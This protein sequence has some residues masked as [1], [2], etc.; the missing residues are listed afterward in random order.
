MG[1]LPGSAREGRLSSAA[2]Q[3]HF[4]HPD[5]K[6]QHFK[7][8]RIYGGEK[9]IP[10]IALVWLFKK[11]SEVSRPPSSSLAP[12]LGIFLGSSDQLHHHR[13]REMNLKPLLMSVFVKQPLW[14]PGSLLIAKED[15]APSFPNPPAQE[16]SATICMFFILIMCS[17]QGWWSL[18]PKRSWVKLVCSQDLCVLSH[19]SH[20]LLF[21]TP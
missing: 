6:I 5:P 17:A 8:R 15:L 13:D 7:I 10:K 20:V 2:P 16:W 11:F 21:A 4:L 9:I 3:G 1:A 14:E 19:F 12:P 18:S